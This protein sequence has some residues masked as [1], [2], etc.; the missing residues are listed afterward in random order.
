M[1][2]SIVRCYAVLINK[3]LLTFSICTI[4]AVG[5]SSWLVG[6]LVGWL[7]GWLV[8]F[9]MDDTSYTSIT[10]APME[11]SDDDFF[12]IPFEF[13]FFHTERDRQRHRRIRTEG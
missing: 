8:G 10:N 5:G 2:F 4:W 7:V 1:Q 12:S 3:W 11:S 13:C 9:D 6:G